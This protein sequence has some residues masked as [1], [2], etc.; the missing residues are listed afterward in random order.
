MIWVATP[1]KKRALKLS[2]AESDFSMTV[3]LPIGQLSP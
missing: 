1:P 3:T 2:F